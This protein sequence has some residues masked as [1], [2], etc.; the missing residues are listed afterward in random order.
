MIREEHTHNTQNS[1]EL[2]NSFI[3]LDNDNDNNDFKNF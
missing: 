2:N 3:L 1:P